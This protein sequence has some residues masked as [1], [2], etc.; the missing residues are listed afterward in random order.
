M[1]KYSIKTKKKEH[2]KKEKKI[3]MKKNIRKDFH[4]DYILIDSKKSFNMININEK[5]NENSNNSIQILK[6]EHILI[7]SNSVLKEIKEDKLIKLNMKI[8]IMMMIIII[9]II[10]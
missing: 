5:R 9:K 6:D 1:V 10:F 2:R 8:L 4:F 7:E 3:L